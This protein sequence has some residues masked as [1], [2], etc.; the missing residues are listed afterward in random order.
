[1]VTAIDNQQKY[2]NYKEQFK[3]LNK[4]LANGFHLEAM[5]IEY[6]VMEDRTE[7]IIR[8]AGLWEAYL[9]RRGIEVRL[10]TPRFSIFRAKLT[11]AI[12]CCKNSL[13]TI[14]L[15]RCCF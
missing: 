7:S 6:A 4:A 5:F 1:M 14:C 9:R 13:Q 12:N 15:I 11:A 8:H 3:R 2:E 10:S